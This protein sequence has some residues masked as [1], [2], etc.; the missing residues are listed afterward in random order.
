V[1]AIITA[2]PT[3]LSARASSFFASARR[4]GDG[5]GAATTRDV[6]RAVLYER[7]SGWS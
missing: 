6:F 1:S 5:D 7:T 4:A 2:L 3:S